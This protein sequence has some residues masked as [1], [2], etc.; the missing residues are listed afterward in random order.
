MRDSG[1]IP[2]EIPIPPPAIDPVAPSAVEPE[3]ESPSA[4]VPQAEVSA[5]SLVSGVHD[6]EEIPSRQPDRSRPVE[7]GELCEGC[8][9]T[10][11]AKKDLNEA[12]RVL[13]QAQR[14]ALYQLT[15]QVKLEPQEE[16][17]KSD[18]RGSPKGAKP[19]GSKG[20]KSDKS[21]PGDSE[22]PDQLLFQG[23]ISYVEGSQH[24]VIELCCSGD[25][26]MKQASK[27][28][29]AFC[30]GV[31][32]RM[33]CT[34]VCQAVVKLLRVASSS[35][36]FKG[37]KKDCSVHVHAYGAKTAPVVIAIFAFMTVALAHMVHATS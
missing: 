16:S 23:D 34:D 33:Q 6:G 14:D 31:H 12:I 24:I 26:E 21:P 35:M 36:T 30:I 20:D 25:S 3:A 18:G 28:V 19:D 37:K 22:R 1:V 15:Q 13:L 8:K 7:E 10:G 29:G 27:K 11:I 17:P 5:A 32:A 4:N 9:G 2:T